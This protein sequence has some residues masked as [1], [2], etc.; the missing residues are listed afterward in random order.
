MPRSPTGPGNLFKRN[1]AFA[2]PAGQLNL[3]F[4][5]HERIEHVD[6]PLPHDIS[7]V[8]VI[9]RTMFAACDETATI[10]RLVRTGDG[11]FHQQE[12]VPVGELLDLPDGPSGEMDIEGLAVDDDFLW[13][14]GSHSL[15][16]DKPDDGDDR[17]DALE[18]LADLDR[19]PNRWFLG[20]LP[21]RLE[22]GG[23]HG[24]AK[25]RR[26]APGAPACLKMK[27]K[28]R[29]K[30]TKALADD[31]HLAAAVG[32][33]CKENGFDVEGL[34][35]KG[36]RVLLG[37]RGPVIRGWTMV[38]EL[39]LKEKQPGRLKLRRVAADGRRYLK[40]FLPLG[41]LGVRDLRFDGNDLL[42]LG[43]PTMEHDGIGGLFRWR[44]P[45]GGKTDML[46]AGASVERLMD[47]VF[48]NGVDQAEGIDFVGEGEDRLLVVVHD[49]PRSDR[50]REAGDGRV[51]LKADL[52]AP[53]GM[54]PTTQPV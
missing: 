53:P 11:D 40:H 2:R 47:L 23:I 35:V 51:A 30:L 45:L 41:G 33:P 18:A 3:H 1:L 38:L 14:T 21:L 20:R 49:S 34:A 15:K 48:E 19:D 36:D 29:N 24:I 28:G 12:N 54:P 32:M 43:G 10:E 37:L 17:S 6:D 50:L 13:I 16:R 25:R 42:L 44:P 5:Q 26:K 7:A 27:K 9:G 22:K 8:A 39:R 4:R 46:H 31:P 52:Y